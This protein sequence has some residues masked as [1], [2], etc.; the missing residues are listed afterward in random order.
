MGRS[1]P[2]AFNHARGEPVFRSLAREEQYDFLLDF[3]CGCG[4]VARKLA[5]AAAPMPQ[6]YVEIDLRAG[7]IAWGARI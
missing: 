6:R 4:P 5:V 3:G 7:M 2:E 1:D